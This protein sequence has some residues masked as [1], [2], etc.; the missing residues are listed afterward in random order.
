M[1][2]NPA[3]TRRAGRGALAVLLMAAT[4]G[5]IGEGNSSAAAPA[6]LISVDP[7]A[8]G[9]MASQDSQPSASGD[10]NIVA[11]TATGT[12][13]TPHTGDWVYVRNRAAGTTTEVTQPFLVG[14]TTGGVLSR[15]GCHVAYWGYNPAINL[16]FFSIAARWAIYTWNPCAGTAPVQVSGTLPGFPRLAEVGAFIGPLSISA[17]GR[18]VAYI[19]APANTS[20]RIGRI[21]T[22]VPATETLL[23]NGVYNANSIDITDDGGFLAVGGQT[24]IN[25]RTR[26]VVE[27]WTPPC[28]LQTAVCNLELISAGNGGDTFSEIN[29]NPSLSA[30]GRYVAFTSNI[31]DVIGAAGLT[32]RQ[33]YAR[34]RTAGVTKLV[35]TSPGQPMSGDVDDPEISPDGSQ[36]A[37]VQAAAPP[38]GAK[39]VREVFVAHS[40]SGYFDAAAFDLVSY[41]VSGA[42][43]TTDSF[44]PSMSSN[45]RYVAFASGANNELSGVRTP[46][47]TN[48]WMRDRP[49]ALD[50]TPSLDFGTVALGG[51]SVP[52]NAVVTNTSGVDINIGG[53]TP[54]ASPFSIVTNGC[55]G[56]LAP[57]ATCAITIVFSPTAAG[58]ASSSVTVAGDGLSVSASLVGNGQAPNVPT[59]GSLTMTPGSANYGTGAAGTAFAAKKFTVSNPGQTAVTIAGV[60]LSGAGADQFAIGANTCTGSLGPSA[61]CTIDVTAT[62]TREGAL[63]A[64]LGI[65]GTAGESA[66]ATLR[67]KGTVQLYTPTLQMN[68][69]VVSA[70]EITVAIGAG[71]PPNIDVQLAFLDEPPLTTVHADAAGAFRFDFLILRNGIRIGGREIIAIDQPQFSGVFAPLLIDLATFR[72]AGFSSPAFTSGVRSLVSRGG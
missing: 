41:G 19:A 55:G 28:V 45:G 27:G 7:V 10:G 3:R 32:T 4:V 36:V 57:G 1:I 60:G 6:Q 63:S 29:Y 14:I 54:P 31:P 26:N 46:T 47:T 64:T 39:P 53:V 49:I 24:T 42:P 20:S 52:Q 5:W 23:I 67:V 9:A 37:L 22:N 56:L 8:G 13:T 40:I 15:D 51:Q 59:P 68:P 35:S 70:G 71:F 21:D 44:A 11:F 16:G 65:L 50:I 38:A 34:D 33:V 61:S 12:A 72:P 17:D 25:D 58:G 48:V 62:V 30:D 2:R 43:T 66:Q 18:Y 69:G